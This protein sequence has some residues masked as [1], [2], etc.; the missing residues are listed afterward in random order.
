MI[1]RRSPGRDAGEAVLLDGSECAKPYCARSRPPDQSRRVHPFC[2]AREIEGRHDRSPRPPGDLRGGVGWQLYVPTDQARMCFEALVTA[3]CGIR[4][5]TL[6][7]ATPL[8][9]CRIEKGYR[10]FGHD[11]TDEITC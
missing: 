6:R 2:T 9:S 11:I 8:D 10:H 5:E 4:A 7:V 3:G 1:R